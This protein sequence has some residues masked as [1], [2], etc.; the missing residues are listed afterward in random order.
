MC[1]E[2][3]NI[4]EFYERI[5]SMG[6]FIEADIGKMESFVEQSQEVITEF[7]AIKD[8]FNEINQT[9][10][11]K[12]SGSGADAYKFETDHILQEIGTFKDELDTLNSDVLNDII[13]AYNGLDDQL[14]DFNRNPSESEE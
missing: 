2:L 3:G 4:Y 12:W 5:L 6:A 10:L 7:N 11:T 8:K 1:N 13:E 14:G 9:L